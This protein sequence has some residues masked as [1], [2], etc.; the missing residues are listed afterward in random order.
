MRRLFFIVCV[1][2]PAL[3][4]DL[5]AKPSLLEDD[6]DVVYF[7]DSGMEFLVLQPTT[8]FA[9]KK[10]GRRLGVYP[11]DTRLRLLAMTNQGYRVKGK[12]K[13]SLVSGWVSPKNLASKDLGFVESLKKHYER[14]MQIRKLVASKE[15]AIG[16]TIM[17][18]QRSIGDPT[19][20]QSRV[21]KDGRS[22][23]WEFVKAKEQKHYTTTVDRQTGQ[24]FR[25]FSH[26][27]LEETEKLTVEF[28]NNVVTAISSLEDNGVGNLKIIVP[29]VIFTY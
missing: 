1:L 8:V 14:E 2:L 12:A 6:P 4:G 18:V 7:E 13:H 17:E 27:T 9:T 22:G 11:I 28:V 19:K 5:S 25:R 24:A 26:V 15:V 10:G 21:T 23:S 3:A 20:K 16:M 29:P